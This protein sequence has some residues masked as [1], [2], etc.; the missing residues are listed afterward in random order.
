MS[1]IAP[2]LMV[3]MNRFASWLAWLCKIMLINAGD[4]FDKNHLLLLPGPELPSIPYSAGTRTDGCIVAGEF[5]KAR[6][7]L[8]FFS[9]SATDASSRASP[10]QRLE[11]LDLPDHHCTFCWAVVL[12]LGLLDG[13][14]GLGARG[15]RSIRSC[16][17]GCTQGSGRR[18]LDDTVDATEFSCSNGLYLFKPAEQRSINL[19]W[20]TSVAG[21]DAQTR[22]R[23]S[24]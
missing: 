12:L 4:S 17:K 11:Y 20:P 9:T 23:H 7:L 3:L 16:L 8:L 13:I 10:A 5:P 21:R 2:R 1:R 14:Y 18:R 6:S 22:H 15:S 24:Q 19:R